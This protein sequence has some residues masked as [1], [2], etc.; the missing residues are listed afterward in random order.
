MQRFAMLTALAIGARELA[1]LSS[2]P[3]QSTSAAFPSKALP[4][5]LHQKYIT[6]ADL[7]SETNQIS[8]LMRGITHLAI[9]RG[10][11]EAE[12]KVPEIVR[13]KQLRVLPKRP[14]IR[15]VG[16]LSARGSPGFASH[17]TKS[18]PFKDIAVEHFICPLINR[19]WLY[20]RDEQAR[21]QRSM[22]STSAYRGAGTGMILEATLL[23]HFIST[24]A[25][26][27]HAA[28]H[29]PGYL[30]ILVPEALE[31]SITLGTRPVSSSSDSDRSGKEK[32]AAVLGSALE[33]ALVVLDA[34]VELD[35]GRSLGLEHTK[36]L[37]AV[38]EWSGEVFGL[39]EKGVNIEGGGD[40]GNRRVRRAA[41]SVVIRVEE[42][43]SRWRRSMVSF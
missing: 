6:E 20:L 33:L 18:A 42:V 41:A 4:P 40:G 9:E 11:K 5:A 38:G 21:E 37:L 2:P 36:L 28:H 24:L 7:P 23:S 26:L 35:G 34:C 39:V 12:E 3:L 17:R 31:V 19:F 14:E 1:D 22:R 8:E 10:K 29:S 16:T 30:P 27:M 13:E 32:E 43:T 25:V 15:E